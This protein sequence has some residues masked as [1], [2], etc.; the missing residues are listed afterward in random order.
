MIHL[1]L[2]LSLFVCACHTTTLGSLK[3]HLGT[4]DLQSFQ[5]KSGQERWTLEDNP[6][7]N[8][9][10][11]LEDLKKL[12]FVDTVWPRKKYYHTAV[13][14]GSL[15]SSMQMRIEFLI[16]VWKK[17]IRFKRI[18]FLTGDRKLNQNEGALKN[19]T[20]LFQKLWAETQMPAEL[21]SLPTLWIDAPQIQK[22]RP[23]TT[24]TIQEWLRYEKVENDDILAFSN[25]PFV[26][27]QECT[28]KNNLPRL[29][30]VEA[31]GPKAPSGTSI[32]VYVDA[33]LSCQEWCPNL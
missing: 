2:F 21:R 10:L 6:N 1:L 29:T 5:R 3:K 26:H 32:S 20:A 28:L 13:L 8:K 16:E 18:V 24:S 15:G 31:V 19:E 12:G 17:D 23:N 22:K 11:I 27:Y 30:Q 7:W 14:L 4:S 33:L 25:Q 9:A